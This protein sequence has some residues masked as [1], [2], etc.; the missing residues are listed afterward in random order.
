MH[1]QAKKETIRAQRLATE[2][3]SL[4]DTANAPIFGVDAKLCINDWNQKASQI[5]G[6]TKEEVIGKPL[7]EWLIP[8][9]HRKAVEA[10]LRKASAPPCF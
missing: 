10:V 7:L 4:I 3:S 5:S 6:Y 2:L 1:A 8:R 9:K